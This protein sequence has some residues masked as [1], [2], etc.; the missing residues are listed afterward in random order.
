MAHQVGSVAEH[1]KQNI[2][3]VLT[4]DRDLRKINHER[5]AFM[6]PALLILC[7]FKVWQ[8]RADETA[9]ESQYPLGLVGNCRDLEHDCILLDPIEGQCPCQT[10]CVLNR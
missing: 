4:D 8:P 10:L 3:S 7:S 1:L 2:L 6:S 5:G 9:L